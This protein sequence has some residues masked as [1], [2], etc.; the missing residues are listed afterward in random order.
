MTR[1]FP[2]AKDYRT[3]TLPISA[4]QLA[5]IEQKSGGP[6]LPGQRDQFQYYAMLDDKGEVIGYTAAVTQKGE[7]GA[8]EFVFGLDRQFRITT[9]YIQRSRER[10][11]RFKEEAFLQRFVGKG[12]PDAATLRDPFGNEGDHGTRAVVAGLRKELAAFSV[13]VAKTP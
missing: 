2:Q 13:L 9:L 3:V 7:F 6:V 5:V 8:I 1:L 11:N 4:A 10:R 12:L